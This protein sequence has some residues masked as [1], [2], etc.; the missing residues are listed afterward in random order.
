V[1]HVIRASG[2]AGAERQLLDVLAADHLW[3]GFERELRVLVAGA[4]D[5][6]E[7]RAALNSGAALSTVPMA[8]DVSPTALANLRDA[9]RDYDI[10]HTHLVHADWHALLAGRGRRAAWVSTKHNHDLFRA[11]RSFLVVERQVDHRADAVIAISQ[12]LAEFTAAHTGR[13][14]TVIPYGWGGPVAAAEPVRE[15]GPFTLL[16]VGRLVPQK[17]FDTLIEALPE[18]VARQPGTRLTVAGDGPDRD[19]LV[20]RAAELGV[21]AS[22]T[23]LG[24]AGAV[25]DLMRTHD[26]LVHP[27]RWEGFGLVLLEAMAAGLPVIGS[28]AGAIPEVLGPAAVALVDPDSAGALA[29]AV[30]G[31]LA[32]PPARNDAR[33]AGIGEVRTRLSLEHS[34]RRLRDVYAN[35]AAARAAK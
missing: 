25:G 35:V 17:G 9:F 16:A 13:T 18:I 24:W 28:T 23:F 14:P 31:A 32:D 2:I 19:A 10:V 34:V 29:T 21:G 7:A 12:S 27:A 6:T 1:L 20:A 4:V 3:E 26:L 33:A 5:L 15:D 22:V 8:S 11:R 30:A